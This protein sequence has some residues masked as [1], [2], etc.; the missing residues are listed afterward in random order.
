MMLLVHGLLFLLLSTS[1]GALPVGPH[2]P[3]LNSRNWPGEELYIDRHGQ[4]Y[5]TSDGTELPSHLPLRL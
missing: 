5:A 3:I 1:V 4:G 2:F